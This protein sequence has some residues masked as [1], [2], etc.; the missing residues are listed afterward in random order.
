MTP[1]TTSFRLNQVAAALVAAGLLAAA[2]SAR[3][4][5]LADLQDRKS[6]V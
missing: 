1:S 3:A 2:G 5:Q 4:D 6:V